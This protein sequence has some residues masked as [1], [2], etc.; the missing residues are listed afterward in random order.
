MWVEPCC[1]QVDLID[2]YRTFHLPEREYT[3][4][5]GKS[6]GIDIIG[7]KESLN[8]FKKFEFIMCIFSDHN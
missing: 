3:F 2:I 6:S 5:L 4:S 1:R 8:I 7:Y